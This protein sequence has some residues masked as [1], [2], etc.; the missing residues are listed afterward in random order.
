[1]SVFRWSLY[2]SS[3][4]RFAPSRASVLK[5]S[6]SCSTATAHTETN[7]IKKTQKKEKTS[8]VETPTRNLLVETKLQEYLDHLATTQDISV[9][10]LEREYKPSIRP[11]KT[12]TDYEEEYKKVVARLVRSF[13]LSQLRTIAKSYE[14]D[15]SSKLTKWST[16]ATIVERQWR[17]P[18]L[19]SIKQE[20][21]DS[22]IIHQSFLLDAK[23]A[24]LILGK[25]GADLL[26]I[27]S[28]FGVHVSLSSNPLT[29]EVEGSRASLTQLSTYIDNLKMGIKDR[30]FQ[31]P[32]ARHV[33]S[34][35]LQHISRKS[36][37]FIEDAGEGLIRLTYKDG[38]EAAV[39]LA[40]RL[41]FRAASEVEEC[42]PALIYPA[43]D[44]NP[45]L[46][47][48]SLKHPT[49]SFY[50]FQPS[51]LKLQASKRT[52]LFR[53]RRVEDWLRS[54]L[55][56]GV[57]DASSLSEMTHVMDFSGNFVDLRQ[58]LAQVP[59]SHANC[60]ITASFGHLLV[61]SSSSQSS[62]T[63][64]LSGSQELSN[65]LK[66][67]QTEEPKRVFMS[68]L[69]HPLINCAPAQQHMIHRLV[70][71]SLST[72]KDCSSDS[73][74][75]S[76]KFE[77]VLDNTNFAAPQKA[78]G[79]NDHSNHMKDPS[80]RSIDPLEDV[81]LAP[82]CWAESS[83]R[84][85]LML[86]DRPMDIRFS[87]LK[88][89]IIARQH[90]PTGLENYYKDFKSFLTTSDQA[91]GQPE[92]PSTLRKDGID[93]QLS[94]ASSVRQTLDPDLG[95][96][97]SREP[98]LRLVVESTLDLENNERSRLC[99][100]TC[101]DITSDISWAA[102]I[103]HCSAFIASPSSKQKSPRWDFS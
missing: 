86:P 19:A 18:S 36:G 61:S 84:L 62:I 1:M 103:R 2:F 89:H 29:L 97:L 38:D 46:G 31:L 4:P 25:D 59:S 87:A 69:P 28:K 70:Y 52:C 24:F 88:N 78:E 71:R 79:G 9:V 53:V 44:S 34:D 98:S 56:D 40:E 60:R 42:I 17:W 3:C 50:P 81:A 93:Y 51:Q 73:A 23:E 74:E 11:D 13:S 58:S 92:I 30:Y 8:P 91:T 7:S 101:D 100:V 64:P 45:S 90:W 16:A 99:Q 95:V 68:S 66:W 63:P 83:R 96:S 6:L 65:L 14:I 27:S 41:T 15:I 75:E 20:K 77:L 67:F 54:D 26:D 72:T 48:V 47:Q 33:G 49:Y 10:D 57:Q 94:L 12:A 37:V 80:M 21:M 39:H 85:D 102:F 55:N 22:E 5:R 32:S 82:T 35:S 76:I 43:Q